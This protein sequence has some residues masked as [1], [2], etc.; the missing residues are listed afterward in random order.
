MLLQNSVLL[1]VGGDTE[2][3][4]CVEVEPKQTSL[5]SFMQSNYGSWRGQAVV[6]KGPDY[7]VG[8]SPLKL[9]NKWKNWQV[10]LCS[11]ALVCFRVGSVKDKH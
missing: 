4:P 9:S 5:Y 6:L 7:I 2:H 10:A 3:L 1:P 11:Y 8:C